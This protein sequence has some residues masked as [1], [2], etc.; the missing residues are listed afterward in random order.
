M[1]LKVT[2]LPDGTAV[3][4]TRDGDMV[5]QIARAFYGTHLGTSELIYARNQDLSLQPLVLPAGIAIRLP[6]YTPPEPPGQIKLW[7]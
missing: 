6:A 5:D 7:D 2:E 4:E 3:Y 1:T